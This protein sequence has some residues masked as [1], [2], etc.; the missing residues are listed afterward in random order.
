MKIVHS[1]Y[2]KLPVNPDSYK[3]L[4]VSHHFIYKFSI[5]IAESYNCTQV[6]LVYNYLSSVPEECT[7]SVLNHKKATSTPLPQYHQS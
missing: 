3:Y 1:T 7:I 6:L 5:W 2:R 4:F